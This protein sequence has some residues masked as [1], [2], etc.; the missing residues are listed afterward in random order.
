MALTETRLDVL[1]RDYNKTTEKLL[2]ILL[3]DAIIDAWVAKHIYSEFYEATW[4]KIGKMRRDLNEVE[5]IVNGTIFLRELSEH[6]I[7]VSKAVEGHDELPDS[8]RGLS[9]VSCAAAE[10]VSNMGRLEAKAV[11]NTI[12]TVEK[13]YRQLMQGDDMR[14]SL[15]AIDTLGTIAAPIYGCIKGLIESFRRRVRSIHETDRKIKEIRE[16]RVAAENWSI[17]ATE[18]GRLLSD[19]HP[20]KT[21]G[22]SAQEHVCRTQSEIVRRIQQLNQERSS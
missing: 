1:F 18:I 15:D 20:C 10:A 17:I 3:A 7:K 14:H 8:V 9:D 12:K 4:N 6:V 16:F 19:I 21:S 13:S 22:L 5:S 11:R 2:K